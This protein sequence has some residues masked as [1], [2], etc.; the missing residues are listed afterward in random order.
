MQDARAVERHMR[1]V[2]KRCL[3][4]WSLK[5]SEL[6]D[7]VVFKASFNEGKR[8]QGMSKELFD[9]MYACLASMQCWDPQELAKP[10]TFHVVYELQ[11]E[12]LEKDV[13]PL[14]NRAT[15]G[16]VQTIL[17]C[18]D[19]GNEAQLL[20]T[21]Q[22]TP[23]LLVNV[24]QHLTIQV[25]VDKQM[26]TKNYLKPDTNFTKVTVEAKKTFT[27]KEH[28]DWQYTFSLKYREPYHVTEDLMKDVT[29]K[30]VT[31]CDPPL[32]MFELS[33]NGM[34]DVPDHTYFA[35]SFLCKVMDMLPR[36]WRMIPFQVKTTNPNQG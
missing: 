6:C 1:N 34:K 23:P 30:D 27:F 21:Y 20:V 16:L 24:G 17:T 15:G 25:N 28:F 10:W 7:N 36:P 3:D 35:D 8:R 2:A 4:E 31:F 14:R 9:H 12:A 19:K 18:D 22:E 29:N 13:T 5:T 26:T 33:C 11:P 32:C